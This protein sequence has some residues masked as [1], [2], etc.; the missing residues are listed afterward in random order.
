MHNKP[1][2]NV[3]ATNNVAS[4]GL[5]NSRR[6]AG[7]YMAMKKVIKLL[8]LFCLFFSLST[9]AGPWHEVAGSQ[10]LKFHKPT[11]EEEMWNYVIN[12]TDEKFEDKNSYSFKYQVKGSVILV[13][14]YCDITESD[15]KSEHMFLPL[16]GGSCY[17][18]VQYDYKLK[19]FLLVAVNGEA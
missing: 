9:L 17:F 18:E 2:K 10:K 15:I 4:T 12:I 8:P 7:R 14:A 19:K 1:L 5:A 16:D 11:F 3:P 6:L 13:H